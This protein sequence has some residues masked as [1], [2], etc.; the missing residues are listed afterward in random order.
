MAAFLIQPRIG[1]PKPKAN[2]PRPNVFGCATSFQFITAL[3]CLVIT[4]CSQ[5]N[6]TVGTASSTGQPRSGSGESSRDAGRVFAQGLLLPA[7]G[8]IKIFSAPGDVVVEL[9]VSVG[10]QVR[11]G[12]RLA[13]MRSQAV[14]Q[15]RRATLEEQ[16]SIALREQS[17]AVRQAEVKSTAAAL[18]LRQAKA[19]QS[20]VLGQEHS[21][22]LGE[23]QLEAAERILGSLKNI[24]DDSLTREFVGRLEVDRQSMAVTDARLRLA[25]QKASFA[26]SKLEAE[27]AVEM[28]QQ[29]SDAAATLLK[30]AQDSDAGKLLD[31]QIEALRTE[32]SQSTLMAPCDAVVLSLGA[33][34]GGSAVQVPLIELASL[35]RIVC[36]CEVNVS[37]ANRIQVGQQAR[38]RSRALNGK[39]LSGIVTDKSRLV[40]R[41]R[42]RSLDPLAATDY[43]TV[44]VMLQVDN[45]AWA[46]QWLQLQVEV[47]FEL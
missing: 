22:L 7:E 5:G 38:I 29:E 25:E 18:A 44:V 35:E 21:I 33:A 30:L 4:G 39:E 10:S 23:Q 36:E 47:V 8:I 11:S 15:A 24:A 13:V 32:A 40:G 46:S 16:K 28:A 19:Q 26:R 43:R 14:I 17:S 1:I 37:D 6:G 20:M 3:L 45:P 2:G 9:P 27:L 34:V 42:L 12:D 31:S 41:P